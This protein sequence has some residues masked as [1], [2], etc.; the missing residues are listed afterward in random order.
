MRPPAP[1]HP[2]PRPLRPT[3][4][5]PL[6]SPRRRHPLLSPSAAATPAD[7][8]DWERSPEWY[9]SQGGGW[10]RS[11]G[12]TVYTA[13]SPAGNGT[14]TVTA[15]PASV[16]PL[17]PPTST[18]EWRVLRFGEST[19][20]SV[21]LVDFGGRGAPTT[22]ST[23]APPVVARPAAL[24]FEYVKS[25]VACCAAAL[26][27]MPPPLLASAVRAGASGANP[28][29]LSILVIGVGGGS[30]PL[31]LAALFPGAAV[32]G[33]DLCPAVLGA[34]GAMGLAA[35]ADATPNL[36]VSLG[37]GVA[38]LQ[39]AP[40][41]SVDLLVVDAF[42]G[43]DAV[44]ASLAAAGR[45]GLAAAAAA[46][47]PSHGALVINLHAGPKPGP[48]DWFGRLGNSASAPPTFVVRPD[49]TGPG[50]AALGT[51]RAWADALLA[52]PGGRGAAWLVGVRRQANVVAVVTRAGGSGGAAAAAAAATDAVARAA[53]ALPYDVGDRAGYG[54]FDLSQGG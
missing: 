32:A 41:G 8:A 2:A 24:A 25:V 46:L 29:T 51:A 47:H 14:V 22:A 34:A 49:G 6:P 26:G 50:A 38:A 43:A 44:P 52:E 15:H 21:A 40:P 17:G 33:V 36:A 35:A 54:Y 1:P 16:A 18:A 20:Q 48:G 23:A 30:V 31:A 7:P 3:P 4:H 5:L 28:P 27:G 42:D 45:A 9:G 11:A 39:A 13:A 37:D 53:L 12:T 10:G 19:R